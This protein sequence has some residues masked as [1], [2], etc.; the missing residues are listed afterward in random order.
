[1]AADATSNAVA[2]SPEHLIT[3]YQASIAA[4]CPAWSESGVT[5][6][7]RQPAQPVERR[8]RQHEHRGQLGHR[9]FP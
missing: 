9:L 8:E 3:I 7:G 6:H 1:M 5:R 2:L 4:G